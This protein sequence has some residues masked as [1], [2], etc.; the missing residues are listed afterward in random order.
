MIRYA[1]GCGG[2]HTFEAWFGASADFDDQRARGLLTCPVCGDREVD[3]TLMTPSVSRPR[4][5][6]VQSMPDSTDLANR[7][8]QLAAP[9]AKQREF[10]RKLAELRKKVLAEA[11]NV[12]DKFAEEARKIHYGEAEIRGIYGKARVE[13]AVSL[14]DEGIEIL[15][16]PDLPEDNN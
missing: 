3:K 16:L 2:G 9:T 15:P 8:Q 4:K 1:L 14:L 11:E 6:A 10:L 13:E 5:D 7:M 12:G